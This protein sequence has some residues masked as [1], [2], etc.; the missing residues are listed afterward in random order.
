MRPSRTALA[1]S[2]RGVGRAARWLH[3]CPSGVRGAVLAG[4]CVTD[5]MARG[6]AAC[7]TLS[8]PLQE[9]SKNAEAAMASNHVGTRMT[10]VCRGHEPKR[11]QEPVEALLCR[12]QNTARG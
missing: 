10:S 6:V 3:A 1:T 11:F 7:G 8:P 12:R 9:A 5:V 2:A 4:A